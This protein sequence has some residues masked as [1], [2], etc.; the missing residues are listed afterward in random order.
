MQEPRFH[1]DD[2]VFTWDGNGIPMRGRLVKLENGHAVVHMKMVIYK[3]NVPTSR[4][5][6]VD[7]PVRHLFKTR[8]GAATSVYR[9]E[10]HEARLL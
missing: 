8:K 4:M 5:L 2:I 3:G 10:K 1:I 7:C 6:E 9:N